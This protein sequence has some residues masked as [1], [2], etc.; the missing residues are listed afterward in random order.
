MEATS[1]QRPEQRDQPTGRPW[2]VFCWHA[3]F[4]RIAL[5]PSVH[6]LFEGVVSLVCCEF[7]VIPWII[8]LL[9]ACAAR[10]KVTIWL[11][12]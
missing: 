5:S 6:I 7:W 1:R 9:S 2:R 12:L 10:G 8:G 4:K 3:S 11:W